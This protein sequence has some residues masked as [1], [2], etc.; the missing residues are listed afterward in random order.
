MF[1]CTLDDG[2]P[3]CYSKASKH[4]KWCHAMD[5][6]FN[7]LQKF[8]TCTLVPYTP[9]MNVVGCK[10]VYRIKR[11]YDGSIQIDKARLV[12]KGFHQ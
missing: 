12:T 2:E 9:T 1:D 6:E 8:E 7:T 10:W 3:T 5:H 4:V 11:M